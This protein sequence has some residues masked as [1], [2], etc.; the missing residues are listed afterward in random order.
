MID[1]S[2]LNDRQRQAVETLEGPLLILAG[3]GSGKTRALTYRI[4]NLVEH[5]VSPYCILALTFTNK[6]AGEM[7]ERVEALVGA[8]NMWV[9]TFHSCCSRILRMDID[10]LGRDKS[11]VIY[12]SADQLGVIA[13][14]I[15][16]MG[17][18]DKEMP[19]HEIR[20]K[21]SDAKNKAED[22]E[23][24]LMDESFSD[25]TVL[26]IYRKYQQALFEAN[27]MDFDDLI[28][29]TLRLFKESPETLEKYRGRFRYVLVDEYQ[30][31][32]GAQYR[33]VEM[34]CHEHRNICVVGDDDQSIY[35]W[36]GADIRNILE[37]EKDFQGA[38]VIRLEQNYRSTGNILQAA[39]SVISHN[40]G[41]KSKKLWTEHGAGD[42][43]VRYTAGTE[44]EEADFICKQIKQGAD[45]GKSYKDYAVLYRMNA[46]SR[47]IENM[48]VYYGIPYKVY[49]G[50]RFYERRE[51]KD[52]LAYLRLLHN[53]ADNSAL[54]RVINV[55]RRGIG[56]ASIS[57]LSSAAD[58]QGIP[59][60]LCAMGGEGLSP[61][62]QKKLKP[63]V[64]TILEFTALQRT[65]PLSDFTEKMIVSLE[66]E[67][68]LK[69]EDKKGELESRMD[70]LRELIGNIKEFE[71]VASDDESVLA[72]FLEN[73]A[74]IAD[75]DGMQDDSDT[76]ALMTLH[77][78]K[79]L[80]F[81]Y[82]F[83]PGM[84]ENIFPSA[85]ARNDMSS[86][87]L[88]EERRLC[89]VGITR[90]R[91]KL[92]LLHAKQRSLFGNYTWNTPSRFFDEIPAELIEDVTPHLSEMPGNASSS[93]QEHSPWQKRT[94][95]P[96]IPPKEGFGVRKPILAP[97][98][99]N[100]EA[101]S[102]SMHQR[103]KHDKFGE[104]TV[105]EISGSGSSMTVLI[106]F[107]DG[108]QKKFA[109]A[110]APIKPIE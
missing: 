89:Y 67:H 104:G 22:P 4:A 109:A 58:S 30:D 86:H 83:I 93:A 60:L 26:K 41:R 63:F 77:S 52:M 20:A 17:Y 37:F 50:L 108:Q 71:N 62:L 39:N 59:L 95:T 13:D 46:Q 25:N 84:E 45:S 70:N 55:P 43:L 88:E 11:F 102:F 15:K 82:V 96:I 68:F 35:G 1:L 69:E 12:D 27:A 64:D 3:A 8:E 74:L 73:V 92:Y 110:Y 80:E 53:P 33:L 66:Y 78:A 31:T 49:G 87:A 85:R 54:L 48:L 34:L 61:K 99:G 42:Q 14:I 56:D 101:K 51:I 7:R 2:V 106:D 16:K 105:T 18:S 65:I 38:K 32:N 28:L 91:E 81:D 107:S 19:K 9:S 40:V 72:S 94:R 24:Y 5:G 10:K 76:V 36:R 57:E 6:A 47:V 98:P 21:I 75:I 44:R 100:A 79:G 23:A 97:K 103:V 90:A 29:L